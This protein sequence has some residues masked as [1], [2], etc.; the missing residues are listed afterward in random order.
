MSG[1][2]LQVLGLERLGD[3]RRADRAVQV[4]FLVGVGLDG[5]VGMRWICSASTFRSAIRGLA[6]LR[7]ADLVALQQPQVVR[8]RHGGQAVRQ[9]VVAAVAGLDLDQV[10]LLAEVAARPRS[11]PAACR[12]GGPCALLALLRCHEFGLGLR[13]PDLCPRSRGQNGMSSVA[14]ARRRRVSERDVRVAGPAVVGSGV[15]VARKRRPGPRPAGRG[16]GAGLAAAGSDRRPRRSPPSCC[17]SRNCKLSTTNFS[18]R[19]LLPPSLSSHWS[20]FRWPSM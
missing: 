11:A 10:A 13:P 5:D 18:L 9:Q 12:R 4:A 3:L 1:S 17:G 15:V 20:S 14:A 8:G 19:P 7:D 2:T 6:G 16:G